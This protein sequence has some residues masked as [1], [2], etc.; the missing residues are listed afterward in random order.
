MFTEQL[1]PSISLL[2]TSRTQVHTDEDFLC[3]NSV[4]TFDRLK[5]TRPRPVFHIPIKSDQSI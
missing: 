3:V 2:R 5:D 4:N 1:T